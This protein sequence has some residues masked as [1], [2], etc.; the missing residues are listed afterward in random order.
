MQATREQECTTAQ[1]V[2]AVGLE[3][4]KASWKLALQDGQREKAAIY[5]VRGEAAKQRMEQALGVIEQVKKKWGIGQEGR[6]VV[7]YEA[8][9]DGFWLARGMRGAGLEVLVADAASILVSRQARRAKSDRLDAISL[10]QSLR[11]WLAGQ[12]E[13]LR[14][15]HE[16]PLEAEGRR[17]AMR[18]RGQLQKEVQQ[19]RDR[20]VKLLRTQGCWQGV[21]GDFSERLKRGEIKD[22]DGQGLPEALRERLLRECER[23][24]QAGEQLREVQA[25]L[26]EAQPEAVRRGIEQLMGLKAV[27]AVGASRLMLELFWREFDNRRQVG[28][29]VGLVPQPYDSGQM[30]VDQGISKQGNRRVRALLIEMAWMWLRYQPQSGISQWFMQRSQG[31]GASKRARRIAI[32]GLARRLVI[33]LWRYLKDGVLPQGALL[34][35]A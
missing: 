20:I 23:V 21:E 29:C 11:G 30:R 35:T 19:H 12:R 6:V 13:R 26:I 4:A 33:A 31:A 27:G 17:H 18:E 2:L 7:V 15:V 1:V 14:V 3:L 24:R 28:S 5:T 8:G 22:Y 9:Q 34:K 25:Q 32:V 10:V 16:P